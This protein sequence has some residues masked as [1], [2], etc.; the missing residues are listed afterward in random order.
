MGP[1]RRFHPL[2]TPAVRRLGLVALGVGLVLPAGFWGVDRAARTVYGRVRAGLEKQL[3]GSLGHPVS[4]GPYGGLRPWGLA[5]G[6]SSVAEGPED[7]STVSI[8]GVRVAL[9][10]L[11]S[12]G[13]RRAVVDLAIGAT[14]VDLRRNPDGAYWVLPDRA[15]ASP[16]P[17][18]LRLRT[19]QPVAIAIEP[20]G[21]LLSL[22]LDGEAQLQQER[23]RGRARLS[24]GEAGR[25]DLR[26]AGSWGTATAR[27]QLR[28]DDVMLAGLEGLAP[29]ELPLDLDG[30]LSGRLDLGWQKGAARCRGGIGIRGLRVDAKALPAPLSTGRW[31]LRCSDERITLEPSRWRMGDWGASLAG[32]VALLRSFDLTLAAENPARAQRVETRLEGPWLQPVLEASGSW[33]PGSELPVKGPLTLRARVSS[34]RRDGLA[35]SLDE[36]SLRG[37]SFALDAAGPLLPALSVRSSRLE[38][39]P[40]LWGFSPAAGQLLGQEAPLNGVLRLEGEPDDA[41]VS[42]NLAQATNL[43]LERWALQATWDQAVLRLEEFRSPELTLTGRMP[44]ALAAAGPETGPLDASLALESFPLERLGGLLGTPLDG[45]FSASGSLHGAWNAVEPELTMRLEDPLAGPVRLLEVWTGSLSGSAGG[46]GQLRL[47]SGIASL[48]GSLSADLNRSWMPTSV[49]LTRQ[50]GSLSLSGDPSRYRW[51]AS[52][53][54]LQGLEVAPSADA[55]FLGLQGLLS[56][57]GTLDLQPL[58]MEGTVNLER[59]GVAGLQVREIALSGQLADQRLN[60]EG[61]ITPPTSGSIDLTADARLGGALEAEAT[62]RG[63]SARW[64]ARVATDLPGLRR[65][66][67]PGTGRAADLADLVIGAIDGTIDDQLSALKAARRQVQ[68]WREARRSGT[69]PFDP[70]DLRGVVDADLVLRGPDPSRLDLEASASGHLWAEGQDRDQALALQPF[71]ARWSGPVQ[72]GDGEFSLAHLPFSLLA[73]F[74]PVPPALRGGLGLAGRYSLGGAVPRLSTELR[75]DEARLGERALTLE[76]GGVA[77][78]EDGLELDLALRAEGAEEPVTLAGTVPLQ[79]GSEGLELRLV[80]RGDSLSF[81]TALAGDQVDWQQGTA[82]VRL[83]VQ[84]A[85]SEPQANGFLRIREGQ[86]DLAGQTMEAIDSTV[87]FDFDTLDVQSFTARMGPEGTI[88]AKGA[89]GLLRPVNRPDLLEV[90]SERARFVFPIADVEADA[91]LTVAGALP[92]MRLSGELDLARGAITPAR[93][94]LMS[95]RIDG[96]ESDGDGISVSARPAAGTSEIRTDAF[97]EENWDFSE[98]LV[99]MG[100]EVESQRGLELRDRVPRLSFIG[101]DDL[102]VRI[103]PELSVAVTPVAEFKTSGLLTLNGQLDETLVAQGL[104]RLT[105]GRISLFTTTFNLDPTAA[106]VAVFTRGLGLMP[107]VDVVLTSRVSESLNVGNGLSSDIFERNGTGGLGWAGGQLQLVKV[108][109]EAHG[110]ADQLADTIQLRSSPPLP[111]SQ[112]LALIG[113]N[114]LAGLSGGNAGAALAAVLGQSLLSPVLGTLSEAFNQRLSF[115]LYPTYATPFVADQEETNSRRVPPQLVLG[116]EVGLDVTDRFNFSVLAAPNRNDIPPQGTVTYK[117]SP[118]LSV[119]GSVDTQGSWQSQLQV[120]LRF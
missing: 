71:E 73:L 40:G 58:A 79:A 117:V 68:A 24:L 111:P 107:Y 49:T 116:T 103:G 39:N 33:E 95:A 69:R 110:P 99:L 30:E 65:G 46:G 97:R 47:R 119:E 21:L 102:R 75:F 89:I 78:N 3:S 27:A 56:G 93:A 87:L 19:R 16:P 45:R 80:G 64:L 23:L 105:R 77:L 7:A 90:T 91:Q 108:V 43:I 114:S 51:Q 35:L 10:P 1:S 29:G 62:A 15:P 115:A 57:E 4:L 61:T 9:A 98:P 38:L 106:N 48:P 6:A 81:L 8:E 59:P 13:R 53:M 22:A 14:R 34:D 20:A 25:I 32:E 72:S 112:L 120:F 92:A 74:A 31:S 44:L 118:N 94:A 88:S 60:L 12:I 66:R 82:D 76:K 100:P 96:D 41:V 18:D 85:L 42:L 50:R 101:F 37:P 54:P 26:G 63:L 109:L 67:T 52:R 84:G 104:I 36:A 86:L 70:D 2:L 113:G 55:A 28:L 83:I 17:L 11:A 5:V